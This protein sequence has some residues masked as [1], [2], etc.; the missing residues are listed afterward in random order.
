MNENEE[1][2]ITYKVHD[3]ASGSSAFLI[4]PCQLPFLKSPMTRLQKCMG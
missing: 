1:T 3:C 4:I 2:T